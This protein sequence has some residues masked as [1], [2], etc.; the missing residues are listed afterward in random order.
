MCGKNIQGAIAYN[1]EKVTRGI[2]ACIYASRF[3]L[4][5]D[6]L[7]LRDKV[8]RF[9]KLIALNSKVKTNTVHISLNFHPGE[10]LRQTELIDIGKHYLDKLGFGEQPFLIYNH[11]DAAHPHIH[12]VTTNIQSNGSRID[13]HNI[14]RIRSEVARKDTEVHF[15]LRKAG[16]EVVAEVLDK[17]KPLKYGQDETKKALAN[18]VWCVL[19]NY[20]VASIPELNAV[21]KPF[22][23]V[24]DRGTKQSKMFGKE[25]LVYAIINEKGRRMGVPIKS[26][27]MRGKPTIKYLE[28]QFKIN[29]QFKKSMVEETRSRVV[30]VLNRDRPNTLN[31]LGRLLQKVNIDLLVR[32]N[33]NMVVYG[34]TYIDHHSKAV[35]NGSELGKRF[36][37]AAMQVELQTNVQATRQEHTSQT[38]QHHGRG[39]GESNQSRSMLDDLL[40]SETSF[41][42]RENTPLKKRR[43]KKQRRI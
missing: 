10:K 32:R 37:P 28:T 27:R 1:E 19:N 26:S 21:L 18:S 23:V 12:L 36:S 5:A 9:A 17:P 13:L 14:G 35:F 25:G 41:S 3:G 31:D 42:V 16:G 2:A 24:A 8:N 11:F 39:Q 15:N 33:E 34:L 40:K 43:R 6:E 29:S 22:N 4:E 7:R 38:N 30:E 20:K